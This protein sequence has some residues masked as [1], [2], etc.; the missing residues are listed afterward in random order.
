M[1][2]NVWEWC[3]DDW[4]DD[5]SGAPFEGQ[6]WVDTPRGAARVVRGGSWNSDA[7]NCRAAARL[8]DQ[9]D[10]RVALNGFRLVFTQDGE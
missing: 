8:I 5:Y 1:S 2:G 3:E 7:R 9:P 6:A 10:H 4:H